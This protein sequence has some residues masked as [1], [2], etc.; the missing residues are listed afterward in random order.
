MRK[1]YLP[2]AVLGVGGI[3]LLVLSEGGRRALRWLMER[4]N[5]A[6][7]ALLDFNARAEQELE[8][9]QGALNRLADSLETAQ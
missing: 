9:I 6:P 1:W 5:E 2:L 8:R 3:G 4:A 7:D